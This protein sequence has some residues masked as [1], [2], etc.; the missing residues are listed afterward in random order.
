MLLILWQPDGDDVFG[1]H[2]G[3]VKS[4]QLCPRANNSF[5]RGL[6]IRRVPRD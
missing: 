1:R 6:E 4:S 2:S 3:L 5:E